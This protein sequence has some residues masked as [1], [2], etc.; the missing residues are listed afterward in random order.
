MKY[1]VWADAYFSNWKWE[2]GHNLSVIG[3]DLL[4]M[5]LGCLS[6][7]TFLL[8]FYKLK[9]FQISWFKAV[10]SYFIC[11]MNKNFPILQFDQNIYKIYS[12]KYGINVV[13][14]VKIY[15][16]CFRIFILTFYISNFGK[17]EIKLKKKRDK[18][19]TNQFYWQEIFFINIKRKWN[20]LCMI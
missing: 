18:I 3:R 13:R 7:I 9:C 10:F 16:V 4:I 12:N 6:S 15:F 2:K 14:D 19:W 5:F 1:Q 20:E 11:F 17:T 8:W